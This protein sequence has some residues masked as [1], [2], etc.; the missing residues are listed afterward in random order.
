VVEVRTLDHGLHSGMFGGPVPDALTALC[1]LLATLHD[2]N[3]DVAVPGLVRGTTTSPDLDEEQLRAEAG[4]LDGVRL[5]GTGRLADRV[6]AAPALAVIGIDAPPVAGA[7]NTL[8]PVARAKV[9][10]R[11]APGDDAT[12]AR[13]ALAAH[14]RDHAPWGA[15]VR[16]EASGAAAPFTARTGGRA[17]RCA[18]SALETAWGTPAVLAGAGG[19]IPFVTAYAGRFP[20]AEILITG[21]EDP[22]TRAH[23]ANE[24]LHLATFERAC[25]AEALL[26]GKLGQGLKSGQDR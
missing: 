17:Y 11:V 20:D 8:I 26:L 3:G 6:S 14:L 22:D 1:R 12:A 2:E 15:Q 23:G 13:D 4:L 10:L 21:V 9:S 18:R 5:T 19:S 16:V 24:S 25:L 7:S